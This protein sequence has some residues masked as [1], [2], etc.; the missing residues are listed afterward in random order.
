MQIENSNY[1]KKE[2]LIIIIYLL[3][4]LGAILSKYMPTKVFQYFPNIV[5]FGIIGTVAIY[6]TVFSDISHGQIL[7]VLGGLVLF[8]NLA[9]L[10]GETNKTN[11]NIFVLAIESF[12]LNASFFLQLQKYIEKNIKKGKKEWISQSRTYF[13]DNLHIFI[14]IGVFLFLSLDIFS[15]WLNSDGFRYYSNMHLCRNWDFLDFNQLK[16]CGHNCQGYVIFALLGEFIF[17]N[18][19]DSIRLINILIGVINIF[20]INGIIKKMC[21]NSAL[22]QQ[23]LFLSILAFFPGIFSMMAE[24]NIDFP[25]LSFMIWLFYSYLN[26]KYVFQGICG[27]LLCFSKETSI[28][29]YVFFMIGYSTLKF[30]TVCRTQENIVTKVKIFFDLPYVVSLFGG[31]L[32]LAYFFYSNNNIGWSDAHERTGAIRE[33]LFTINSFGWSFDYFLFKCRQVLFL[34]FTWVI[35]SIVLLTV[36]FT[37]LKKKRNS[38]T[39]N[40]NLFYYLPILLAGLSGIIYNIIYITWTNYR[41]I[42]QF[43]F[44]IL[45]T[46]IYI[47]NGLKITH[48]LKMIICSIM[49]FIILL[50]NY[51]T[52]PIATRIFVSFQTSENCKMV[53][54][55]AFNVEDSYVI[56]QSNRELEKGG[57]S[58]AM[59]YNKQYSYWGHTIDKILD[60]IN[61]NKDTLIIM[62][63]VLGNDAEMFARIFGRYS[64]SLPYTCWN[65]DSKHVDY[66]A[67]QGNK[68]Q[69]DNIPLNI[70]F[71]NAEE[72]TSIKE[73]AQYS[74]VFFIDLPFG[75]DSNFSDNLRIYSEKNYRY[76]FCK[77]NVKRIK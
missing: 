14:I 30:F 31:I 68:K 18:T 26:H 24:I 43:V 36:L 75:K 48:R 54:T 50:S 13:K 44:F 37:I 3:V 47:L 20:A 17:P 6:Y 67:F 61:Y 45:L 77:M 53:T 5:L 29:V 4:L 71:L 60:D 64:A 73:Y 34:N 7:T 65:S 28:L 35:L 55:P 74:R 27:L 12:I 32:W 69:V 23:A 57:W 62:P 25:A 52:D 58:D 1:S 9:I 19:V 11:I 15:T 21:P 46:S 72:I 59:I 38:F 63:N 22:L 76:L 51:T 66:S 8:W 33:G 49:L 2:I 16:L 41:Y 56:F 40:Q 70:L 39:M 42:I 10:S